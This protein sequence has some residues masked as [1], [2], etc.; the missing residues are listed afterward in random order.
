MS[1]LSWEMYF[2]LLRTFFL[3]DVFQPA[4][5]VFL[6]GVQPA[7]I[8]LPGLCI[9]YF[10]ASYERTVTLSLAKRCAISC[11]SVYYKN[12]SLTHYNYIA[13]TVAVR[14]LSV[15]ARNS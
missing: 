7:A 6:I 8:S 15:S 4:T 3:G 5:H 9:C 2:N 12:D 1:S 13:V 11:L 14:N 10:L